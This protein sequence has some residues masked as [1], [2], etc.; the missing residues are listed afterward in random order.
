MTSGSAL[1]ERERQ[2][3]LAQRVARLATADEE[4]HP[5]IVP[6]CFAFDGTH[7]YTPLDEK[8]KRVSGKQ[9]RRVRNIEARHEAMLL[10]DHYEEDWSKLG[11]VQVFGRAELIQPGEEG[12]ETA[13]ELLRRRYKQY[14]AMNLEVSPVIRMTPERIVSWG[15][16]LQDD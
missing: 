5:H 16:A 9:L 1:N 6:I 4:G 14:L 2:F 13:I 15:A 7:F 12:H 3:V 8:P 11:F 10:F